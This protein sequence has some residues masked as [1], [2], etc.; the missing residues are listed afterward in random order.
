MPEPVEVLSLT[1]AAPARTRFQ[2]TMRGGLTRFVG[3]E[4]EMETLQGALDK[5]AAGAG[6]IVAVAGEAGVGKSRLI[7]EFTHSPRTQE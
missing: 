3:R 5:A 7:R 2:P 4:A 6:Q 1:G